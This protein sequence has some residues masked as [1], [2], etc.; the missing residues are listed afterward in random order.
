MVLSLGPVSY[1]HLTNN[2][3]EALE[4]KFLLIEKNQKATVGAIKQL[5]ETRPSYSP[6]E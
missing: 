2:A 5:G 6:R 1:T 3:K 4:K